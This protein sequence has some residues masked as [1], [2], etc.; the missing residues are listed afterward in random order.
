MG[1]GPDLDSAILLNA[2]NCFDFGTVARNV[3]IADELS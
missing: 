3:A 1:L 2:S